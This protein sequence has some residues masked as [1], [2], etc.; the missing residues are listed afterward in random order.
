MCINCMPTDCEG[1]FGKQDIDRLIRVEEKVD[2]ILES[3]GAVVKF[4]ESVRHE[5]E[6]TIEKLMK[7]PVLKM[8]GVKL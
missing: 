1:A 3:M 6:P 8:L 2:S 5:V 7:S 4:I